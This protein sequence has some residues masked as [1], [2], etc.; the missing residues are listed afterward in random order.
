MLIA[1]VGG[2]IGAWLG[3]AA[4][5]S[6]VPAPLSPARSPFFPCPLKTPVHA[7]KHPATLLET[8]S[9]EAGVE[10]KGPAAVEDV[11]YV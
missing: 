4:F 5:A 2:R 11:V 6:P 8:G 1:W 3:N 10:V 9:A 7:E